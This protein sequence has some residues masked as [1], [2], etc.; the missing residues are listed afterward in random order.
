MSRS[1]AYYNN[2]S[3][4]YIGQ[5]PKQTRPK[6][7]IVT[8]VRAWGNV[9]GFSGTNMRYVTITKSEWF[10]NGLGIVPNALLSE[11]YAPPE[12]NVIVDNDIFW[13]NFDYYAA[14]PFKLGAS[15]TGT[16]YPVG[17]GILLFGSQGTRVERNRIYGNYLVGY[18]ALEQLLLKG[19]VAD[20]KKRAKAKADADAYELQDNVVRGNAFGLGGKD[21]NG[22]DLFYDGSGRGN[23]FEGNALLSPTTPADGSTFTPCATPP[24]A[25]ALNSAAQLEAVN[26]AVGDATHEAFWLKHPHAAKPGIAALERCVVVKKSSC[27]GQRR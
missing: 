27:R 19:D 22:R 23:C 21:L 6:R 8:H 24:A 20:E 12:D 17:V 5:T 9:L 14:A 25:N 7:S 18:G 10:N 3:G 15:A 1:E 11:L 16:P 13:N 2:D 26:W 4:F